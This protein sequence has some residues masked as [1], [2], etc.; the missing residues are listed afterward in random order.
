LRVTTLWASNSAGSLTISVIH[1][2]SRQ[3][4]TR[5]ASTCRR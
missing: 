3:H 4:S 5:S 1:R 2:H